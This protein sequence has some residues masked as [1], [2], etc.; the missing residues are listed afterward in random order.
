MLVQK[1]LKIG[2][3][4]DNM[5]A[6]GNSN[7]TRFQYAIDFTAGSF[8]IGRVMKDRPCEH[9]IE[10]RIGKRQSLRNFLDYLNDNSGILCER[11]YRR[12]AN[13]FA[14]VG[15]KGGDCE[16]IARQCIAGDTTASSDIE[17]SATATMQ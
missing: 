2:I 12:C 16:T 13:N 7:T 1:L 3:T 6:G 5:F 14:W 4:T 8:Q 10:A 17:R 9:N 11:A 15:L